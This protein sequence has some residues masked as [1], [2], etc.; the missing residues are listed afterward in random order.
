MR[1]AEDTKAKV[2]VE[3]RSL[4]KALND[5]RTARPWDETTVDEVVAAAPEIDEYVTRLVAKGRWMPPGYHVSFV[6]SLISHLF[7]FALFL[8]W[9][10]VLTT[11]DRIN[12]RIF[13]SCRYGLHLSLP[14]YTH[15]LRI[16]LIAAPASLYQDPRFQIP[17]PIPGQKADMA[18]QQWNPCPNYLANKPSPLQKMLSILRLSIPK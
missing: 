3:L 17:Y 13:R 18:F 5:I 9:S 7:P 15:Q 6:P 14:H 2:E 16:I 12:S 10:E 11:L 4:E 1:N 8:I